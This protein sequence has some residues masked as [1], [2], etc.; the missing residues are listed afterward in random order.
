MK[1]LVALIFIATTFLASAH[2][3]WLQP[4]K[5]RY[6]VGEDVSIDFLVGENFNGEQWD[7]MKNKIEIAQVVSAY[8]KKD[9]KASVKPSK[10]NNL[11]Y[12]LANE[13]THLFSM[14]SSAADI[15]LDAEK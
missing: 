14:V 15:T 12:K 6:K 10:G 2:E 8:G 13:G 7:L 9:L 1:R 4:K 3:F 11:T 5:F